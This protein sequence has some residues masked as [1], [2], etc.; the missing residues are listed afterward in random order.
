M[1]IYLVLF[2]L[3]ESLLVTINSPI[4]ILKMLNIIREAVFVFGLKVV[5]FIK[6]NV[7]KWIVDSID[8]LLKWVRD[9]LVDLFKHLYESLEF[10]IK[11]LRIKRILTF[12]RDYFINIFVTMFNMFKFI[13]N[14]NWNIFILC[15][16]WL[17]NKKELKTVITDP[18]HE[19]REMSIF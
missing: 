9:F 11:L 12:I 7:F 3:I 13:A 17:F 19:I 15:V 10:I 6:Y 2:I 14:S 16:S 4:Q 5:K 8:K 1:I 18:R